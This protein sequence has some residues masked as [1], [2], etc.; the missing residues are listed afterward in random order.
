MS[1][2]DYPLQVHELSIDSPPTDEIAACLQV[3][4]NWCGR[5]RVARWTSADILLDLP[6][7]IVPK[8]VISEWIPELDDY[9]YRYWGTDIATTHGYDLSNGMMSTI[10]PEGFALI[11][12]QMSDQVRKSGEPLLYAGETVSAGKVRLKEYVLRL[13]L[14]FDGET[15][16]M[17]LTMVWLDVRDGVA[18]FEEIA[19]VTP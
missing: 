7:V 15:T 14:S 4:R 19:P 10:K 3:W 12:R 13:P 11:V 1:D 9:R 18:W 8:I 17:V 5:D 6:P 2:I 16:M